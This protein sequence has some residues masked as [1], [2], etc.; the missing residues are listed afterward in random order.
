MCF[1]S[2]VIGRSRSVDSYCMHFDYSV[3]RT[4]AF[5]WDHV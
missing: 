2:M 1:L 5:D 4:L 3:L